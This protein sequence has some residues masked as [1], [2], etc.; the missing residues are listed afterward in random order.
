[1]A[2]TATQVY[3][4]HNPICTLGSRTEPGLFSGGMTA[5]GRNLLTGEPV[6]HMTDG[7]D[8]GEGICPNCGAVGTAAADSDGK[9]LMHTSLVGS[10]PYDELHRQLAGKIQDET[11]T[12]DQAQA[13]LEETAKAGKG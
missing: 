3:E 1:M 10:D 11:I 7:Q 13:S 9:S 8:F 5:A 2:E 12:S 6:E 4:C